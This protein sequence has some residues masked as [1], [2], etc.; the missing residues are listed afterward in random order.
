[1]GAAQTRVFPG[2]RGG[3]S[4]LQLAQYK[5]QVGCEVERNL[6]LA[7]WRGAEYHLPRLWTENKRKLRGIFL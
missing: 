1:V 7:T 5:V 6:A 2:F 3:G 4:R